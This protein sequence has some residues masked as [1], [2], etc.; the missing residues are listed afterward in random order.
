MLPLSLPYLFFL[1][2]PAPP[3]SPLFPYTTLFRSALVSGITVGSLFDQQKVFDVVVWGSPAIRSSLSS[4]RDLLLDTPGGAPVRLADVADVRI[5]STPSVIT[6]TDISR[7]LDVTA[8]VRGRSV[9]AVLGDV[10]RRV[11]SVRFP[12]EYRAE[13][14]GDDA[15]RYADRSRL[16]GVAVA[17]AIGVFLLLQAA[18]R[19]WRL[20]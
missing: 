13:L 7:S 10:Q 5:A 12:L 16:L 17:A 8:G 14:V 20:A 9:G 3:T 1:L 15:Q 19:S 18:F 6:H 11:D 2:T 4:V